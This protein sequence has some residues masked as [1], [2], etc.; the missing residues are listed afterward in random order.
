MFF[1]FRCNCDVSDLDL[2]ISNFYL[3]LLVSYSQNGIWNNKDII[4][5]TKPVIYKMFFDKDIIFLNDLV[6]C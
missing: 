2:S 3:E 5:N 4:I 6:C 1:F